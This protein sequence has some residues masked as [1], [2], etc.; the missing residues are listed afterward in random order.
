MYIAYILPS[1]RNQ[2]PIIVVKSLS[3]YLIQHGC[4]VD[5]F[6]FDDLQGM[7]FNCVTRRILMNEP[8]DFD[9]YDII[10]SHCLRPDKYVV[11][12]KKNIHRAVVISTLHQDTYRSFRYQYN[13]LLARLFTWYWCWL[14]SRFDAVI[15]ISNQLRDIYNKKIKTDVVTIYNGCPV[16][17][18]MVR[19]Y[20]LIDKLKDIKSRYRL[21][22][23]YAFVTKGK[24]LDQVLKALPE[25][26]KYAVVII[27]EGPDIAR[28]KQMSAD[29][30]IANRVF[31]FP[32]QKTPRNYLPYFDMYVR[33]S[34]SE[35]FGLSMVEAALAKKAIVC[36]NLPSFYEIFPNDEASFFELN[37]I[38]SLK[39]AIGKAYEAKEDL[40]E[41]A[42]KRS[43]E[44]F[45]SKKM[46]ENHLI[47]YK[48]MMDRLNLSE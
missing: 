8:I 22:G 20:V 46:A 30:D 18:E 44:Y 29:L 27:G 15:S 45:T 24:G 32:Y 34:Y 4:E 42:Y 17:L 9:K 35:G 11:K 12:W 33:P 28:L 19:D 26:I 21:I 47:F 23:T 2:G 39:N 3:D 25:L 5:I 37:N 14:Q 16:D 43:C 40:G 41:R 10:H 7:S 38:G 31:F 6:Y 13:S 1:L 48:R 36:S